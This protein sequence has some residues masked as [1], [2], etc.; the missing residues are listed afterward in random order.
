[1]SVRIEFSRLKRKACLFVSLELFISVFLLLTGPVYSETGPLIKMIETEGNSKISD[2]TILSKIRSRVGDAF[3]KNTVQDDIKKLYSIGYFDDIRVDIDPFEGGVKLIFIFTE[4]Q[5]IVSV[6]FQGNKE[7]DTKDLK[8]KITLTAG[9]VANLSLITDNIQKIILFYHTEG[10]WLVNVIPVISEVSADSVALTFQVEEGPKVVIKKVTIEGNKALSVKQIKK[11]MKTKK[12]GLLSFIFQ[13]GI[14]IKEQIKEDIER[15]KQLYHNN[16]YLYAS[17]SEPEI[18][19]SAD[20]KK[21][22]LAITISEGDQFSIAD[23]KVEG[24]TVFSE[25]EVLNAIELSAGEIFNRGQLRDDLDNVLDMYM[26]KGYAMADVNPLVD[27]NSQDKTA[28]ITVSISEDDIYR[29]GKINISGNT[30]TRDKVIRREVRLDEGDI[31]NRKLIKRSYQRINNLNYFENADLKPLPNPD[32]KVVD[33]D[34]EVEEKMTGMLSL[35]GGYSSVDKFMVMGEITQSNLFGKGLYL[36]LR[37]DFSS[38]R[39][40][41]NLS[42]SN[43]WFMDRPISASFSIYNEQFEYP[44]YDKKSTGGSVGFGKELSEYVGG[45]IT[46]AI[47]EVTIT[48]V[49]DNASFIVQEQIG[50]KL[51]SSISPSIWRDTRDNHLDPSTGSR[52]SLRT[53]IAG[54]GGENYFVKGVADS[55]WYF[56]APLNTTFSIRG[57]LGYANGFNKKILPLYERFYVGGINTIR[58]L[59]FGEGGPRDAEGEKIGGNFESILN[60]ELIFPIVKDIKLKGLIFADYG[61][62]FDKDD[63]I[64]IDDLRYTVGF[65]FRWLSPFG[66]LRLEWGFN[67]N[68]KPDESEN[69]VE[70]SMGGFI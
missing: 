39:K 40:N 1:M 58:G 38:S 66:P 64:S 25:S 22:S 4:K 41:Y 23:F 49:D 35:G 60:A 11:V 44:D 20:R 28:D 69:K 63:G 27:I 13:T 21:L 55:I 6:D 17:V 5:T 59:G 31:F 52:H 57:R 53:T 46:Y 16:G 37:T 47:E 45:K 24:N 2:A 14:Y 67:L 34:I 70:F 65:G 62:A 29:I 3:S 36:K 33:L 51:T 50:T 48:D 68:P 30:K 15:I 8:E 7:F 18:T 19:L 9:A 10:Y 42:V 56:P 26:E 32:E 54:L 61:G 43:P 12:R